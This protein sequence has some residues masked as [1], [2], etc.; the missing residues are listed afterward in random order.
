MLRQML[1]SETLPK[2]LQ[3]LLGIALENW[4]RYALVAGLAWLL[5]YGLFKK[6]WWRRKIIQR[7]PASEDVRREIRWSL[8][9][10]LIYGLVGTATIIAG[11]AFGW[12]MYRKIGLYGW[13]WFFTSILIAIVVHDTWF[14]WT[15]RLMHHRRLF[16]L[17]HKVHHESTNPS[18]WAAYSFAPLEALAQAC[19]FPLLA[20]TVPMHP[21]AFFVFMVWQIT[22]NVI[23][24]TG[25]EYFPPWLM[26]SW[27]GRL[28]NT[29]TNH[30][31]HHEK[32]RGN[33]GLY[34]NVWDRLM[35]TNHRDYE[36]RF[37]EVTSRPRG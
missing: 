22:F 25:Y 32:M 34:F 26:K 9:T 29:P 16:R 14:Y 6:H 4:L 10:A 2:P 20:F 35:G 36:A 19:I 3:L 12:Q 37:E 28:L 1:I 24:H 15:H 11:K 21:L 33:Y 18:P 13:G 5:A 31:Q 27:L 23:G 7:D 8:L 30:V 17:F